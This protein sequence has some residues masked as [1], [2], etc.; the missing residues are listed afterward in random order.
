MFSR[1]NILSGVAAL[2]LLGATSAFIILAWSG[3]DSGAVSLVEDEDL[4][5]EREAI[6]RLKERG[7]RAEIRTDGWI[8]VAGVLLTLFPEHFNEKGHI[9]KEVF[10]DLRY[11]RNC[12][13]VLDDTPVSNDG[14]ADLKLLDNLLLLSL[15]RTQVTDEGVGHIEGIVS[16][17]LLRL[18]WTGITDHGLRY[19]D[20]LPDLVMLYVSGTRITDNAM[21]H[22]T[23]LKKLAAL[24]MAFTE[25]S[26]KAC[27]TLPELP[28]LQFLGLDGTDVTDV[29]VTHLR[30]CPKLKYVNL[31]RTALTD[32][33]LVE[34]R[35]EIPN[36]RIERKVTLRHLQSASEDARGKAD[37]MPKVSGGQ[38][39]P[40]KAASERKPASPAPDGAEAAGQN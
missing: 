20:R 29:G 28:E 25:I 24:Q 3:D 5:R 17:R 21:L 32:R 16:L 30:S 2:T 14:L 34:L 31:T 9:V 13:L 23:E 27:A 26:D 38:T 37:P 1:R 40:Q 33:R 36:C 10:G 12:F 4:R 18:N 22:I 11:L 7:C 19:I 35:S 6:E 8:G 15:Q 39:T